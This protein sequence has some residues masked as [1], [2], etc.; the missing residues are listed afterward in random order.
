MKVFPYYDV[1]AMV[2]IDYHKDMSILGFAGEMAS[3]RIVSLACYHLDDLEMQAEV[4]F[5]VHPDYGRNGIATSMLRL[6]AEK[7]RQK[8]VR[9]IVSYIS[10]ESERVFGVFQ[11]LGYMV[12]STESAG[13]YE[14]K[15]RLDQRKQV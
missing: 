15:V 9:T 12:E 11:K 4:D 14:I 2:N 7:C 10:I 5:A 13:L 8:G 3:E 6:I 1:K